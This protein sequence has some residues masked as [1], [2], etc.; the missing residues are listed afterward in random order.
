MELLHQHLHVDPVAAVYREHQDPAA[1]A[2]KGQC[3]EEHQWE[4]EPDKGGQNQRSLHTLRHFSHLH[5]NKSIVMGNGN[6]KNIY[7]M[8][9]IFIIATKK[10]KLI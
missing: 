10:L 1:M 3:E 9:S 8:V 6:V 5:R 7:K 2:T 4:E